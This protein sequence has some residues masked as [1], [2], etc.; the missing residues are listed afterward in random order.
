MLD[1]NQISNSEGLTM[2]RPFGLAIGY[3]LWVF[4]RKGV[5]IS[6]WV[7]LNGRII[8]N[9]AWLYIEFHPYVGSG[10]PDATHGISTLWSSLKM[11]SFSGCVVIM[12]GIV[13]EKQKPI[14]RMG[15][16]ISRS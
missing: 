4:M 16:N 12:G 7:F 11:I 6:M 8:Y 13:T 15:N 14:F 5:M 9:K 1:I 10:C 2:A 3:V